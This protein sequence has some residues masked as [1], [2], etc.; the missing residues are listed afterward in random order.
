MVYRTAAPPPHL[1]PYVR[2]FWMYEHAPTPGETFVHRSMADGCAELIFHYQHTFD[3]LTERGTE[4][5]PLA[6]VHGQSNQF[7]RFETNASF[8][9]FGAYVYPFALPIFF[10]L[11]GAEICNQFYDYD[12]LLGAQGRDLSEQVITAPDFAARIAVVSDFM[13][14]RLLRAH[15]S[16]FS[17]NRFSVI[18]RLLH[19]ST[20]VSVA[21]L[22]DAHGFSLRQL[23]RCAQQLTGFSP[24]QLF[25][26]A[27][28]QQA[29]MAYGQLKPGSL[30]QLAHQCGYYDQAHFN[31]EFRQFSGY[32]PRQ[33]FFAEAEGTQ[34]RT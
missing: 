15:Q 23:E 18:R 32:S 27:R 31:H 25:R 2:F 7:R 24:K 4:A 1:A 5:T 6:H 30:T 13:T 29:T 20:I 16:L 19:S 22:A 3:I 12:T 26:I 11:S 17:T 28:F 21:A 14:A 33:F 10:P 34:F 8:G 9:I